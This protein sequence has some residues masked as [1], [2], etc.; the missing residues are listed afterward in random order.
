[1]PPSPLRLPKYLHLNGLVGLSPPIT[2]NNWVSVKPLI[3]K[4]DRESAGL[5]FSYFGLYF[6]FYLSILSNRPHSPRQLLGNFICMNLF[7][8]GVKWWLEGA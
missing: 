2:R 5:D 6:L 3:L 8:L 7:G 1:M 4:G